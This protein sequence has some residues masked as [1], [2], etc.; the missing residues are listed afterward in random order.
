[1]ARYLSDNAA[2]AFDFNNWLGLAGTVGSNRALLATPVS[3]AQQFSQE[4]AEAYRVDFF[5]S[6][7]NYHNDIHGNTVPGSARIDGINIYWGGSLQAQI[8]DISY[9]GLDIFEL[10]AGN[11]PYIPVDM[12]HATLTTASSGIFYRIFVGDDEIRG[13]RQNDLL[14]G[15]GGNDLIDGA[16][17]I[18]TAQYS[19]ERV[20]YRIERD[21][22]GAL[23]VT[24]Q[25]MFIQLVATDQGD[26]SDTLMN[27]ERL[28]FNDMNLAFDFNGDAGTVATILAM[29][30]GAAGLSNATYAGA[31]LRLLEQG[32]SAG[33][34]AKVALQAAGAQS[35]EAVVDLLWQGTYSRH[36]SAKEA[37]PYIHALQNG[38]DAGALTLQAINYA[39]SFDA[40]DLTGVYESGLAYY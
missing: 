6:F 12:P 9:T 40:I 11:F 15:F 17:G 20:A 4:F 5:G 35:P 39:L 22:K 38:L 18:D 10:P 32:M 3:N 1:M 28:K 30:F 21:S 27:V 37:L 25:R 36:P 29:V 23:H 34:L 13:G 14:R 26:G 33:E 31:G 19:G 2:T 16:A 24:D 7:A 8:D